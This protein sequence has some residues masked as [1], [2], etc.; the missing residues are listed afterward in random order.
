MF[1]VTVW[2][3]GVGARKRPHEPE[4]TSQRQPPTH[5]R[6]H[7]HT[8]AG[9]EILQQTRGCLHAFVSGAG[10][11]GTIAGVSKVLKQHNSAIQVVLADPQGSSLYN[12]VRVCRVRVSRCVCVPLWASRSVCV[13]VFSLCCYG[14]WGPRR[15]CC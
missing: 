14:D 11:G 9:R 7:P 1:C 3:G 5:P 13:C 6:T 12:K 4:H 2:R 8:N 10:T 15:G